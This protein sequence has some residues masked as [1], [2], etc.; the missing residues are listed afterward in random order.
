[1]SKPRFIYLGYSLFKTKNWVPHALC[2]RPRPAPLLCS[3]VCQDDASYFL[4]CFH[5][6]PQ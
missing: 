4:A 3:N 5:K 6:I 2:Q 1:M